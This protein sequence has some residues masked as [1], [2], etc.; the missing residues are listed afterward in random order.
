MTTLDV[1]S[2]KKKPEP[3]AEEL[4]ARE[5]VRLA[6][7]QG[8]SLT[9]PDGLLKR[10]TKTVLETA[11]NEE[12]TEHLGYEKRDPAGVG[13]GNVRNGTRAKTV[14]TGHSGAV[15]IDVP[16]DRAGTFEPQIVR[17]R[18]RR[19]SDIDQLVLSLT[20]RGLTTGEISAHFAE[21]GTVQITADRPTKGETP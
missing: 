2:P 18:Q 1:V 14:L 11:L 19:L 20:A 21:I 17:K 10:L 3:S 12:M 16:R 5:L 7:E 13:T 4:A 8:L 15:E 9:G 6:K